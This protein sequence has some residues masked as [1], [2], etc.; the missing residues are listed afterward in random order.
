MNLNTDGNKT[1][2][3]DPS[4]QGARTTS[5]AADTGFHGVAVAAT[6][7]DELRTFTISAAAGTVGIAISAGVDVVNATTKAYIGTS[8]TVTANDPTANPGP[9]V[10]VGA[11]D[12]FY[13]LAVA[14]TLALGVVG[15]APAVGVNIVNDTTSAFI[16]DNATVNATHS[17]A[18][19]ATGKEN[20]VMIGI[21]L[22]A[23]LVGIGGVV[24]VL[25]VNNTTNAS[26]GN[27]ATVM[28][29]GDVFVSATDDTHVLELS[30]A[31]G[32]GLA[33]IGASVGVMELTKDTTA[34]IGQNAHVD[35]MGFGSGVAG[36]LDGTSASNAY[37]VATRHG[38]IVQATSSEDILHIVAA[39]GFGFVGVSGAIALTLINPDTDAVIGAGAQIN[40]SPNASPSWL[41][42]VN[43]NAGD[44]VTIHTYAVGVAAGVVGVTGAVDVGT[45]NANVNA[46]VQSGAA[47][48]AQGDIGVHA[49]GLQTLSGLT[50]SGA[51]GL[52][53]LGG[54]VSVWSIGTEL[55]KTYAD[56][57]GKSATATQGSDGASADGDAAKQAQAGTGQ[58][59]SSLSTFKGGSNQNTS[60]SRVHSANAAATA[61]ISAHAPS[62]ASLTGAETP[63]QKPPA[64]T[65]AIIHAGA[66]ATAGGNIAVTAAE[67]AKV[68]EMVGQVAG[69]LVGAGAAV[70]VLSLNN[71]V[72]AAADGTLSAGGDV[73]VHAG[74][75]EA[76]TSHALD[77]AAGFVGLGAAVVTISDKSLTQASL[78]SVL[79]ANNV[80]LG[81]DTLRQFSE[82]TAQVSVGAVGVGAS[83]TRLDIGGGTFAQVD[84]NA[85]IGSFG[86]A[87]RGNL[88]VAA[89]ETDQAD[90]ETFAVSAG[91]GA[92]GLNF[93]FLTMK[94][95]VAA[96]IG[97]GAAVDVLGAVSV[98]AE[99]TMDGVADTFGVAAGG[100]AVGASVVVVSIAPVV[101][102]ALG[103]P[104]DLSPNAQGVASITAGSLSVNAATVLPSSGYNG[105]AIATGSGGA[106]I[107][108]TSTNAAVTNASTVRSFIGQGAL[109]SI[110]GATMVTA[111]NNTRQKATAN[112][113]VGGLLAAGIANANVV[114]TTDTEATI[115]AG[116]TLFG[117][118]LAVKAT[119]TDDNFALTF[120]GSGGV[121]AGAGAF[122][123][124]AQTSTT[125]AALED[126]NDQGLHRVIALSN[127]ATGGFSLAA[128]H[129]ANFNTQVRTIAG[130][131]LAGAGADMGNKDTATVIAMLG[132]R[133]VVIAK[134]V[135]VTATNHAWKLPL[136]G[137]ET[138]NVKGITG[139]LASGA[140][141]G[142]A[143]VLNL[144]TDVIIGDN[145]ILEAQ[146]IEFSAPIFVLQALN[147]LNIFDK[148]VFETGGAVSGAVA[149][150]S[151]TTDADEASVSV[152]RNAFLQSAGTMNILA[153]GTGSITE[154][155]EIST[156]GLGTLTTGASTI[157]VSPVNTIVF[158]AGANVIS[159]F[160]LNVA[161]GAAVGGQADQYRLEARYDGTAGSAVPISSVDAV[162]KLVQTNSI[163]ITGADGTSSQAWL[164]TAQDANLIAATDT[165]GDIT[166]SKAKITSWASKVGDFFTALFGGAVT[167]ETGH[168]LAVTYSTV[169]NDGIVST[170]LERQKY[171]TLDWVQR[172]AL[173]DLD[174]NVVHINEP[175]GVPG[176]YI[177]AVRVTGDPSVVH[178]TYGTP[179]N[180]HL[181]EY[182]FDVD[183]LNSYGMG[184]LALYAFY[185]AQID[186]LR[187]S[188]LAEG[189]LQLNPNRDDA[190][191]IYSPNYYIPNYF[192]YIPV[193]VVDKVTVYDGPIRVF[194]GQVTGSGNWQAPGDAG[195]SINNN[196][197]I[198][199]ELRG[200]TVPEYTGG[201]YVNN[202]RISGT[203]G[204]HNQQVPNTLG[205]DAIG[206]QNAINAVQLSVLVP[207]TP[208]AAQPAA[209]NLS[210]VQY[211]GTG[212]TFINIQNS[213]DITN[214]T[215]VP[216]SSWPSITV[217]GESEGGTGLSN[218]QGDILLTTVTGTN[219]NSKGDIYIHGPRQRCHGD[220]ACRRLAVHHGPA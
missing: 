105:Q 123:H 176:S 120:A 16:G 70:G 17:V 31:L 90:V 108:V 166:I 138:A 216:V 193:I 78:G 171:W 36:V 168:N 35:A 85:T 54:A 126:G 13:H 66:T 132:K 10:L 157:L 145:A 6:N 51:L 100:F 192:S 173:T 201:F 109:L 59:N 197:P 92:T 206:V 20:V 144:H 58:V 155:L 189:L 115:N 162:A 73:S 191:G 160:N 72:N 15:L 30:G 152:G 214:A 190:A 213:Y 150:A 202:A 60:S 79:S 98:D 182:L 40:R 107:D 63:A 140:G 149:S 69:G 37:G 111:L 27:G 220:G 187:I 64:G 147:D 148:V 24:D 22:A 161:A 130:G 165:S 198:A 129:T 44:T 194:A 122:A 47:L 8:A 75:N 217:L 97:I 61:S 188:L 56:S 18:V 159:E 25:L 154:L 174:P 84:A 209:F 156:Y 163:T 91:I 38:L 86:S 53:G 135:S 102:A 177:M 142:D 200:A 113:A 196:T 1:P 34:I 116:V 215:L 141:V 99:A 39:G 133:D 185:T 89:H 12:D 143:T 49:V 101:V 7:R 28:A 96:A 2:V 210:Q 134:G 184:N 104:T 175:L 76:V 26:I 183:K 103:N 207:G 199:L 33:G 146:G 219:S 67:D 88:S 5:L 211:G 81:A 114:S 52:V 181:T 14:A 45:L 167:D 112:S 117:D 48:G 87:I 212:A 119:G 94:P 137:D 106:L 9:S 169:R 186:S 55:T 139:G 42:G 32:G 46:E 110:A 19:E 4:L 164:R 121:V 41:Q 124:T 180:S 203:L 204:D 195:I 80:A 93:A 128:E 77:G 172:T 43:V 65:S 71:N 74:L 218:V 158:G 3:Q 23:G 127:G 95:A 208:V 83:F 57:S 205:N 153:R 136:T 170:G 50:A 11:G 21:G 131:L 178:L 151:V 118:S 179:D 62:A 82:K 68:T 125:R 29:G